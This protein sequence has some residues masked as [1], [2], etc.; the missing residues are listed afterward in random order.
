MISLGCCWVEAAPKE[1]ILT[2]KT[3]LR[4][5]ESLLESRVA[6]ATATG[7]VGIGGEKSSVSTR[8]GTSA[9]EGMDTREKR[10]Q[11][12]EKVETV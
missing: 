2:R 9:T 1:A 12:E 6:S 3:A 10:S 7:G 8:W 5:V 11:I 4:S